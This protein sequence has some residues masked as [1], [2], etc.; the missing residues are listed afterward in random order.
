MSMRPVGGAGEIPAETVRVAQA[1]F[2]K[3]S[4]AIRIRDELGALFTDE[5]F[6][7]LFPSRGRPA[8]SPGRLALITVLQFVEG[9]PDRQAAEAV[10]ARVDW[11]YALNLELTDPGFDHSVLSEF[12]D[13]LVAADGGQELFDRVLAA[14]RASGLLRAGGRAR[15]DATHVLSSVRSLK[16]GEFVIETV[17]AAL[18]ALAAAAPDWLAERTE[19]DWFDRY[20]ARVDNY[21]LPKHPAKRAAI[22]EQ[23]GTDG[24]RILR[25]VFAAQ[26]PVWLRELPAVE[27]LRRAWVQQFFLDEAGQV[28]WRD[29]KNCPPGAMR[30]VTPYDEEVRY[31]KKQET[32]WDGFKVHLTETCEPH[33][34][35]LLTDVTTTPATVADDRMIPVVHAR[36]AQRDLL[37]DEHWADGG[38][39]NAASLTSALREY[40][41]DL[42]GPVKPNTTPQAGSAYGQHAFTINWGQKTATCPRG[43]TTN[44]WRQGKSE[45]GLPVVRVRFSKKDCG[46]CPVLR[47][48]VNSPTGRQ[49]EL[50]LRPREGH[51]AI[52][53]ARALQQTEQWKDRYKVRAGVEGTIS[54]GVQAH[55]LR[56]SRY[57]G[58]T[59]TSLQ[60]QI[61]GAAI[62]LARIDAWLIGTRRAHTRVSPLE[63][64][65]PTG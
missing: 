25:Y 55:G 45:E 36:L 9:L 64:L 18:N 41:V 40:G 28:R 31:A 50:N 34:P 51:E 1:A 35:N 52:Q 22:A 32:K 17:R 16:R 37:P 4:L 63:A 29:L 7:A 3:G 24:M 13:R 23:T 61:T 12:R 49:R 26:A 65:R 54:Q 19:P 42:H 43:A 46:P 10:R 58:L 14:A 57:R 15:T 62:N 38:Y 21:W 59:K 44:S 11:K 5:Q 20:C 48:C 56:R 39:V 2:P 53:H 27:F 8:W 6:A 47:D 30:L 33:T 60:H